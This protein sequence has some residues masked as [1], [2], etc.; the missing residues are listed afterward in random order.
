MPF[1]LAT[2]IAIGTT[3]EAAFKAA[4]MSLK[5]FY[6]ASTALPVTYGEMRAT[7]NSVA[8]AFGL[9][10]IGATDPAATIVTKFNAINDADNTWG[11]FLQS[12]DLADSQTKYPAVVAD[13]RRGR[14]GIT[15]VATGSI[16]AATATQLGFPSLATFADLFTFTRS[17]VKKVLN[18]SAAYVDAAVDAP[19]FDMTNSTFATNFIRNNTAAGAVAGTPGTMPTNWSTLLI[20]GISREVVGVGAEAGVDYI[21]LRFFGTPST[22][23]FCNIVVDTFVPAAIGQVWSAS[24][25]AKLVA[26]SLANT[27]AA[28]EIRE[29][30]SGNT[31]LVNTNT[32]FSLT[33]SLTRFSTNRTLTNA[34]TANVRNHINLAT[35]SGQAIDITIRIGL[36]QLQ[37]GATVT[38]PIRTTG[39]VASAATTAVSQ[40]LL[41]GA[42]TNSI[43]NNS[44]QG[45]AA[46]TPGTLPT[47]WITGASAG[48]TRSVIGTGTENGIDFVDIRIAGTAT[49]SATIQFES[50]TQIA[51]ANGQGWAGSAFAKIAGGSLVNTSAYSLSISERDAGGAQLAATDVAFTPSGSFVRLAGARTFNN[52][53][54]AF[55]TLAISF[56]TAGAV[57]I[58]LR[59]GWPQLEQNRAMS[60]PIRTTTSA[61]TRA[62]DSCQLSAKALAVLARAATGVLV[63]GRGFNNP[64]PSTLGA[65]LGGQASRIL[66]LAADNV[67]LTVGSTTTL[68]ASTT[69]TTP[70]PAIGVAAAWDASGKAISFNGSTIATDAVVQDA[71]F[72]SAFLGRTSGGV[73][74]NGWFDRFAIFPYRPTNAALVSEA[75][76]YA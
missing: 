28:L 74:I 15:R 65:F 16:P 66:S 19:A 27:G 23:G 21:D 7:L 10:Q 44:G 41:E 26:G 60:S 1:Q 36:P 76:A 67:S 40:L 24:V 4:A 71:S 14:Y 39:A 57:D 48:L 75:A 37:L 54:T 73:P 38:D 32:N 63:Q 69:T 6:L 47:N 9:P 12:V 59:I 13:F 22:T 5:D 8:A 11:V 62:A 35:T 30:D 68:A 18:S 49:G 52:A 25:F 58:T 50:A 45:A 46:G 2:P 51:A 20:G 72:A 17:S 64:T 34:A 56:A 33:S 70:T 29:V 43:R 53:S 42:A 31:F 55:T 3:T 61:V